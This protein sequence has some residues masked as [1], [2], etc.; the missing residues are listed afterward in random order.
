MERDIYIYDNSCMLAYKEIEYCE[1]DMTN[2]IS[3]ETCKL[4]DAFN[5]MLER[6]Y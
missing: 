2:Y 1:G 5:F 3:N 4:K 6:G